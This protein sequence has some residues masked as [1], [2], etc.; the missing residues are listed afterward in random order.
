MI[1][2]TRKGSADQWHPAMKCSF[3]M[4]KYNRRPEKSTDIMYKCANSV[5]VFIS[6]LFLQRMCEEGYTYAWKTECTH[7]PHKPF[8]LQ[9]RRWW[10][11]EAFIRYIT[12]SLFHRENR[13]NIS[14]LTDKVSFGGYCGRKINTFQ[15]QKTKLCVTSGS[16]SLSEASNT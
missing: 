12:Q 1:D 2:E 8:A 14:S 5:Y 13:R 15:Q 7:F 9:D 16:S 3:W 11:M 10:F 4:Y 6:M